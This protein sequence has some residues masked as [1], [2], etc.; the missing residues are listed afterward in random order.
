M[1]DLYLICPLFSGERAPIT[2]ND[3]IT[4]V[5]FLNYKTDDGTKLNRVFKLPSMTEVFEADIIL[6]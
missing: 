1:E 5:K 2:T 4:V 3:K 6:K